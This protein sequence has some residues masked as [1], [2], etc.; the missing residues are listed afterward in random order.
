VSG[1]PFAALNLARNLGDDP[2]AV[3]ENHRRLAAE[4]GYPA[5]RLFEVSQVHG[6]EL[7]TAH[8]QVP[9]LS[10][11]VQE[12]D[13]LLALAPGQAV[14]I[15]VA[16]CVPILVADPETRAVLAIH[17]GWRGVVAEVVP[18]AIAAIATRA[19]SRPEALLAAIGPHI[20]PDAFEVG[21]EVAQAIGGAIPEDPR[22]VITGRPRPHADLGRAVRAQLVR[23]GLRP[24]HVESVGGCTFS[25]AENFF[26]FRRDG[27]AAGRHL[28]VIVAGC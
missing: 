9:P 4:V 15:R 5:D 27:K 14:G 13:A 26:S 23:A 22:V 28:A 3:D 18:R 8:D 21:P 12:A 24:Q 19:G 2:A 17:A 16:D 1:P 25:D 11:R 10:F 20:G 7:A 6:S